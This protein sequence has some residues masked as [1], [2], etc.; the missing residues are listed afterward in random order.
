MRK[1]YPSEKQVLKC[2]IFPE[3]YEVILEETGLDIGALR[4]DLINLVNYRLIEVINSEETPDSG[5]GFYDSDNVQDFSY[6]ATKTGLKHIREI[7]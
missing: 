7:A 1:L 2:L 5:R 3:S 6:R 4:D